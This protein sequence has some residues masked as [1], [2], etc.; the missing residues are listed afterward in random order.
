[1]ERQVSWGMHCPHKEAEQALCPRYIP[2]NGSSPGM[3]WM[4]SG[5]VTGVG[6]KKGGKWQWLAL[7][8]MPL[9]SGLPIPHP[10]TAVA[11][12]HSCPQ[13]KPITSFFQLLS[14]RQTQTT[15]GK[16]AFQLPFWNLPPVIFVLCNKN[17]FP[18]RYSQGRPN[19]GQRDLKSSFPSKWKQ[20][21]DSCFP[22]VCVSTLEG[23]RLGTTPLLWG[24]RKYTITDMPE[25]L[26]PREYPVLTIQK[27]KKKNLTEVA[28]QAY[29]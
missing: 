14:P 2:P 24:P 8:S 26:H 21:K 13:N 20:P 25:E 3:P 4:T 27:G 23:M 12:T 16:F 11:V 1:M 9:H 18:R 22:V 5:E 19:L 7:P 29:L 28:F 6:E 15:R 10:H 17:P